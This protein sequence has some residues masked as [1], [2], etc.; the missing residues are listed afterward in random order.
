MAKNIY[1]PSIGLTVTL[2]DFSYIIFDLN[3]IPREHALSTIPSPFRVSLEI[4][5]QAA[6]QTKISFGRQKQLKQHPDMTE[7]CQRSSEQD[8]Q[9][10]SSLKL[11][12]E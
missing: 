2:A 1:F 6:I 9:V 5:P 7:T 3:E 11:K 10:F 12:L 4:M 8:C